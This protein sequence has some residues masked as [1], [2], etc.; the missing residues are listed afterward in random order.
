MHSREMEGLGGRQTP[1]PTKPPLSER[2][3]TCRTLMLPRQMG[4]MILVRSRSHVDVAGD[5]GF[6]LGS[7]VSDADSF[8]PAG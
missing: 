1:T 2:T 5:A 8:A 3:I 4:S 7:A 6:W